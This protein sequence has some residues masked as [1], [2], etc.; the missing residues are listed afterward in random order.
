MIA[1]VMFQ[2]ES[3]VGVVQIGPAD[4]LAITI[5]EI[6]LDLGTRQAG[7]DEQPPKPSLHGRF[8]GGGQLGKRP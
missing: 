8:R 3:P 1:T 6:A 4:E 5:T 2:N 7:L